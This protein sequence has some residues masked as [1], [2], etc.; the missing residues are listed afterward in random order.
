MART[1]T[2]RVAVQEGVITRDASGGVLEE[3]FQTLEGCGS[4]PAVLSPTVDERY[5]ERFDNDEDSWS[6][7]LGGHW[8]QIRAKHYILHGTDRYQVRRVSTTKRQRQ[9]TVLARLGTI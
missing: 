9:T 5:Q 1:Y 3:S 4:I 7:V 6:I 8:P 2:T